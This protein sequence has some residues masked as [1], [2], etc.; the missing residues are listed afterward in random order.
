M[1]IKTEY[2]DLKWEKQK[3][4]K[5]FDIVSVLFTHLSKTKTFKIF[6]NI[7]LNILM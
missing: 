7:N 2:S 6:V 3:R 4:S 1:Q 5:N